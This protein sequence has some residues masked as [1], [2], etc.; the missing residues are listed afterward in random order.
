MTPLACGRC[1]DCGRF[2]PRD[3]FDR[4]GYFWTGRK[5]Y[6][7]EPCNEIRYEFLMNADR[8]WPQAENE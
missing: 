7:C 6:V 2:V 5:E 4:E 3:A 1:E 8:E